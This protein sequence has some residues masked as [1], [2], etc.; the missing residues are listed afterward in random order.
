MSI[1]E[2]ETSFNIQVF[3]TIVAR[4]TINTAV[5]MLY[6]FLPTFSRGIGVPVESLIRLLSLRSALAMLAPVFGRLSDHFGRR[7]IM[8]IAMFVLSSAL[9]SMAL[10][11]GYRIFVV[12]LLLGIFAQILYQPAHQAYISE[13]V[14]YA[15]RGRILAI[16]ELAWAGAMLIGVPFVGW[17]LAQ[18]DTPNISLSR[19]FMFLSIFAAASGIAL[20]KTLS[21]KT[22]SNEN[23]ANIV[24]HWKIV[25][26]NRT[27]LSGLIL[28]VF[29]AGA[30]ESLNVVFA[31]WLEIT[32]G[33]N[34]TAIGLA[35]VVIGVA[36][37]IGEGGVI[38]FSDRYGKRKTIGWGIVLSVI[39]YLALPLLGTTRVGAFFGLFLVYLT[40]EFAVVA[41]LPLMTELMP[42]ERASVMSANIAGHS[43][44]RML[45]ALL[46]AFLLP[47]G[48]G[49]SGTAAA[50]MNII[51]FVFLLQL[52]ENTD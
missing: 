18:S 14:P 5:R 46:G 39:S 29:V 19:P 51:A 28:G 44:G 43:L 15:Q 17:M 16:T 1:K 4:L 21:N 40:F 8:V 37:L 30:N 22:N 6:P 36:D 33:M 42:T 48:I 50:I 45:G 7:N 38:L 3:V 26:T 23:P 13:R 31:S 49:A 20:F 10:W 32:F 47:F 34:L 2:N 35:T 9:V 25:L 24:H 11:P 52:Q 27:V 12:F 41:I